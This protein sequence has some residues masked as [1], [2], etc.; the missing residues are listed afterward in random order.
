MDQEDRIKLV[1][2]TLR[3][4]IQ[5]SYSDLWKFVQDKFVGSDTFA[6]QTFQ[7]TLKIMLERKLIFREKDKEHK[8]KVWYYLQLDFEKHKD[9]LVQSY[10]QRIDYHYK[11]LED[12]EKKFSTMDIYDKARE[13]VSFT[14]ILHLTDFNMRYLLEIY[15]KNKDVLDAIPKIKKAQSKLKKIFSNIE[16][17]DKNEFDQLVLRNS[18]SNEIEAFGKLRSLYI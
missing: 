8:Q 3:G 17:Q 13:F 5:I 2:E 12:M 4:H 6:K 16:K 14:T 11:R 15:P 1:Y 18:I 9:N 7:N 10:S